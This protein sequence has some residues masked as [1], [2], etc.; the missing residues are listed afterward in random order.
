[1]M[2]PLVATTL[3]ARHILWSRFYLVPLVVALFNTCFPKW[4]FHRYDE[5]QEA[6]QLDQEAVPLDPVNGIPSVRI[7]KTNIKDRVRRC[8]SAFGSKVVIIG[9]MF[10]VSYVGIES[11][12]SG[13]VISYMIDYR[14]SDPAAVGYVTVGYWAGATI[15]R[16]AVPPFAKR[17]GES[18]LIYTSMAGLIG[19]QFLLWVFPNIV[20]E[21]MALIALGFLL[22][23][24]Y[25]IALA[26]FVRTM[27]PE[28]QLAGTSAIS[29]MGAL[30][31]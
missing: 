2:G 23:P 9:S 15:G 8:S 6:V 5:E 27:K 12:N 7:E 24:M 13:W 17:Y 19:F 3:A 10:L 11:V 29:A 22:G 25:P 1:M 31:A 4:T 14:H 30:G 20:F 16:F 26:V 28:E 21:A 18:R